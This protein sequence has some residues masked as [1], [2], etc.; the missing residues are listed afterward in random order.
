M[1]MKFDQEG[2]RLI[3]STGEAI[4]KKEFYGDRSTYPE[5]SSEIRLRD[6]RD[7]GDF[8]LFTGDKRSA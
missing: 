6:R 4:I 1:R 3:N 8:R 2:K 5:Y 7:E